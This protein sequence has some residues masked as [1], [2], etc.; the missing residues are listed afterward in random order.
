MATKEEKK[1]YSVYLNVNAVK[2]FNKNEMAI[3]LSGF[4]NAQVKKFNKDNSLDIS[5]GISK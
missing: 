2:A 4:V 5:Q 3:S 1:N